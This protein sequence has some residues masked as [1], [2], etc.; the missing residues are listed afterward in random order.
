MDVHMW[1]QALTHI[2]VST[3]MWTQ[4]QTW[5]RT[6]HIY[7]HMK[8]ENNFNRV[9]KDFIYGLWDLCCGS[10]CLFL[11]RYHT[12]SVVN[13]D[14]RKWKF[15]YL[16]LS[17]DPFWLC[18]GSCDSIWIWRLACQFPLKRRMWFW[19]GFA[20]CRHLFVGDCQPASKWWPCQH[21]TLCLFLSCMRAPSSPGKS[22]IA[23]WNAGAGSEITSIGDDLL[24]HNSS[25]PEA[26]SQP[27]HTPRGFY[28]LVQHGFKYLR[29]PPP[30]LPVEY[31][32]T[33]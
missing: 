1:A 30:P 32:F 4:M 29:A 18:W 21:Q 20:E 6:Y 2:C 19:E 28:Y 27:L 3:H 26:S 12:V 14:I 25:S 8:K 31:Y 15:S 24:G 9:C 33:A 11:C 17:R 10:I 13:F 23:P 7:K 16:T 22:C 5:I